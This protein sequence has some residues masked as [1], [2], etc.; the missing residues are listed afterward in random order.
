MGRSRIVHHRADAA[1][2]ERL[3]QRVAL[4]RAHRLE[5]IHVR[6]LPLGRKQP[7]PEETGAGVNIL[8]LARC[9][10]VRTGDT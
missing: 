4:R 7:M 1:R 3:G 2:R 6:G 5:A 9:S 8:I 10:S